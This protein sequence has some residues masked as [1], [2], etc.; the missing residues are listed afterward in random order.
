[1]TGQQTKSPFLGRDEELAVLL[2]GLAES[3]AGRGG[4]ILLGGEPGIGKSR[5]ADEIASQA[6]ERKHRIGWGR[7]WEDSGAPPYWPWVQVLRSFIRQADVDAVRR[8]MGAGASDI[9]QMLPELREILPEVGPP[10]TADSDAARFQLFDSTVSFLRNAAMEQ[11]LVIVLDD[12]QAADMPSLRLLRFLA[13]QLDEMRVLVLGTFRDVELTPEHPFT[14]IMAELAREPITRTISLKGL[15]RDA[16][17][18]LIRATAGVTPDERLVTAVARG[19]KGNPLYAGEALRL[20]SAEGRLDELARGPSQ[21]LAVPAGVRAVIGKRLARLADSTRAVLSIGAV[22]GPEFAVELLRS[23]ADL[24]ESALEEGLEEALREGLLAEASGGMGRYRFSHDLVRET[25]YDELTPSRRMRLHR[26]VAE[27]LEAIEPDRHLGELAHHFYEGERDASVDA[28]T[29]TYARRAGEQASRALAFEEGIRLYRIAL[30]A[31]ERSGASDLDARLGILLALGETQNRD[32]DVLGARGTLLEAAD[33]AK[34]LGAAS[35]LAKAALG[36]GGRLPW[37]RPGRESKL[38]PLLRDALVMLGGSDDQLRVRLLARLASAWRSNPEQRAQCDALSRQ[39]VELARSLDD[40][41]TLSYALAGRFWGV[42]WPD[43][44]GERFT[45]AQEMS[46]VAASVGDGERLIDAHLMLW[47]SVTELADMSAARRE[48]EEMRRLVVD[49]R[50]PGHVWL[51]IAPRALMALMEGDFSAAERLIEEE[52]DPGSHF[53]LARDNVSAQR[54]HRFLLRREQGR[55]AEE[56]ADVRAS[57]DE[58]TWYPLHRCSLAC[59]LVELGRTAEAQAALDELARGDFAALYPDNEWLLGV[60]L[61]ADATAR[62]GDHAAAESLYPQLAP[63]AGR[64]AI[65]HAEGSVGAV[66]RYLGLLAATLDR[67]DDATRHLEDA[68]HINERMGARPWTAHSRHDLASVL[69]RRDAPGD[70]ARAAEL[71]SVALATA[72]DLRMTV[73]E[74][75]IGSDDALPFAQLSST[76]GVFRREGEYWTIAFDGD[77]LRMKDSKGLG[78]LSRLLERPGQELHALDLVTP[79]A[80]RKMAGAYELS[81]PADDDAGAILDDAAKAAYRQRVD[82]LRSEQAQAEEW[83]DDERAS[84]ARAELDALTAELAAAVGIGGRDRKAASSTERARISV[85]RAIRSAMERLA[86]QSPSFG[87]HLE[88]TV[89]TGTYCSYTPDPRVPIVWER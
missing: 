3:E 54:F 77:A 84:A 12:L 42:W 78:Y 68:V 6:R 88:A 79:G 75:R 69:R 27:A 21:H 1:M 14:A 53:T 87:G 70:R 60:S 67:L 29:V 41:A 24:D 18:H 7:G 74:S 40:G 56:E 63:H 81:V 36:V 86:A 65:G 46:E 89:R 64:H 66:D 80:S 43:N 30:A 26:R 31:L 49:L 16:L 52:T 35:A 34:Q 37:A 8:Q 17:R 39:A 25:L 73:L 76:T 10:A 19:T 71:D 32:G 50:Q 20:L 61:A 2:A 33:I 51:G 23:I 72:R 13:S 45:L 55:L 22:I 38:I 58:F 47:L 62:L 28:R 9:A 4:L 48:V 59:L 83:N 5:L 44:P 85:T 11:P 82:E 15:G 57:V